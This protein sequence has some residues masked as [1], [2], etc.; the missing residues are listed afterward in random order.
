MWTQAI[1]KRQSKVH[2]LTKFVA[3]DK[4]ADSLELFTEHTSSWVLV[5][6]DN[7]AHCL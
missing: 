3:R 2:K 4:A 5:S 1:V 7:I 6:Q